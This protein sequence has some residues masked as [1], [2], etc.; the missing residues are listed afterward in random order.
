MSAVIN[1]QEN[2]AA[3]GIGHAHN[4]LSQVLDGWYAALE[5]QASA[6]TLRN[7]RS[8]LIEGHDQDTS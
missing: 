1:A 7:E 5:L 4:S 8:Q 3:V 2:P 6:F